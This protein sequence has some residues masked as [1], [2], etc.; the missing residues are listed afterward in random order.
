MCAQEGS[1]VEAY[2][3]SLP[4][5]LLRLLNI[6]V[7]SFLPEPIKPL[8]DTFAPAG[9]DRI[10]I[11]M[12]DNFGLFEITYYKPE[13]II[14]KSNA[15]VLLSTKNPYTL[16]VFH[17]IMFGGFEYEPNGFH[18][19]KY[20][21][22]MG[23][24]PILIGRER[25]LKR[26]DGG[27]PSI[28]KASDMNTWIEAAKVINRYD[29]SWLHYLDFEELYRT[30][31]KSGVQTPEELI[32]KLIKRTDKWIL[33]MYKQ[34]RSKSLMLVIGDH[35]RY[36]IDLNYQGKI[37]QWRAASVPLLICLYKP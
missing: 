18:L 12:I 33:S 2:L 19:L 15:T 7:P 6:E 1:F 24:N 25:D 23:K 27:A 34:L 16:G 14:S 4:A 17:Q 5:T 9:V 22:K 3:P 11:N 35:G 28:A 8:I 36:K 31:Q 29:L 20:M 32:E 26:Y 21:Q 10:I 30:R 13:F 37:A